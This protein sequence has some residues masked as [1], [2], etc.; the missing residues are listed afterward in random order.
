MTEPWPVIRPRV[1]MMPYRRPDGVLV[2]PEFR[3]TRYGA[4][5]G[6]IPGV[7]AI[8]FADDLA[9]AVNEYTALAEASRKNPPTL[10]TTA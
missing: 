8:L 10:P 6:V 7:D 3:Q 2:Q 1:P 4:V 9:D 5:L